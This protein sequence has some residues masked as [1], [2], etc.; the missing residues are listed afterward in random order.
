MIKSVIYLNKISIKNLKNVYNGSIVFNK[1]Y[2]KESLKHI[3]GIYGQNG[4]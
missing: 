2:N 3:T 1:E 4:S